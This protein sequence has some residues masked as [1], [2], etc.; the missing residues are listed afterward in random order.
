M[1]QPKTSKDMS[2]R[3]LSATLL[4]A[5]SLLLSVHTA[6]A[7]DWGGLQ[8]FAAANAELAPAAEGQPRIVLMGDSIT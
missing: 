3:R 2:I 4:V 1:T 5:I 7:Q 6:Y 8:R